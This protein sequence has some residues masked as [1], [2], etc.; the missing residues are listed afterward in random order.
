[1]SK[2]QVELSNGDIINVPSDKA[3]S[4]YEYI[5]DY[6]LQAVLTRARRTRAVQAAAAN[7]ISIRAVITPAGERVTQL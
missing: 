3:R 4:R 1:M 6:G 5:S 7:D 2:Y